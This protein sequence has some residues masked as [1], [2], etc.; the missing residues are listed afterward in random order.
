MHRWTPAL[1]GL[2][3]A[4][5]A[6]LASGA[7]IAA[8]GERAEPRRV[9][10][11]FPTALDQ[12]LGVRL[13]RGVRVYL[14]VNPAPNDAVAQVDG[15]LRLNGRALM[16]VTGSLLAVDKEWLALVTEAEPA[17]EVWVPRDQVRAVVLA[18]E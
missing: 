18:V 10:A 16:E 14:N 13:G 6:L 2:L 5:A 9:A 11:P 1:I 17:R 7:A 4:T 15:S 3:L 8:R 12:P